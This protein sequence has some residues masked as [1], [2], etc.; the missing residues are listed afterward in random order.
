MQV[1]SEN[2]MLCIHLVTSHPDRG[3]QSVTRPHNSSNNADIH[4]EPTVTDLKNAV[5][6][7]TDHPD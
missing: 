6:G 1:N 3:Q 2:K 5:R 4:A 7:I